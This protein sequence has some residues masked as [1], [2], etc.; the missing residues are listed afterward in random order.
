MDRSQ[1][2]ITLIVG[3]DT[4]LLG[5]HNFVHD[6]PHIDSCLLDD[7]RTVIESSSISFIDCLLN[8]CYYFL[9]HIY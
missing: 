3:I 7:C 8:Y 2:D 5:I 9:W 1:R 4:I 6:D